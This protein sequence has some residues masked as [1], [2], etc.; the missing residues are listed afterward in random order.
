MSKE[1]VSQVPIPTV[2]QD[3]EV[4]LHPLFLKHFKSLQVCTRSVT[5]KNPTACSCKAC[6][7]GSERFQTE[8]ETPRGQTVLD[9][10]S[11]AVDDE[12]RMCSSCGHTVGS[13]V[14]CRSI[15]PSTRAG[16]RQ[17]QAAKRA[18]KDQAQR[19]E[20][21]SLRPREI[22]SLEEASTPAQ[23]TMARMRAR[24]RKN[25]P[26]VKGLKRQNQL[27]RF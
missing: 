11:S 18:R 1:V 13:E 4:Q 10:A 2:A 9:T 14:C 6:S 20:A 24:L 17:R 12:V 22:V 25:Q 27:R 7:E 8:V 26:Q 5:D 21:A 16:E 19:E 3:D 23:I 15:N